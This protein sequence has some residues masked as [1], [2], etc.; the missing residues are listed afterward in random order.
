MNEGGIFNLDVPPAYLGN[1]IV[2]AVYSSNIWLPA[3][4]IH[5][6][7]TIPGPQPWSNMRTHLQ[8]IGNADATALFRRAEMRF[9]TIDMHGV[10]FLISHLYRLTSCYGDSLSRPLIILLAVAFLTIA[11]FYLGNLAVP[12]PDC[13]QLVWAQDFCSFDA[14]GSTLRSIWLAMQPFFNPF[15]LRTDQAVVPAN[16]IAMFVQIV[17]RVTTA[18]LLFSFFV[19]VRRRFRIS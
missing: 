19:A 4:A 14:Y 7:S 13:R 5:H 2:G 17:N 9:E 15:G 6:P 10:S 3:Q 8:A 12:T 18:G 1:P 11:T 16:G